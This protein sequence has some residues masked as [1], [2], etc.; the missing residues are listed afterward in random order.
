MPV[1]TL[2]EKKKEKK[3]ELLHINICVRVKR[4]FE[5]SQNNNLYYMFLL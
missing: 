4:R 3:N 2:K 5:R 1:S